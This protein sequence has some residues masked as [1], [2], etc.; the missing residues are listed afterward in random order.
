MPKG[1]PSGFVAFDEQRNEVIITFRGTHTPDDW[2]TNANSELV[3]TGHCEGCR[4][5]AGFFKS[6]KTAKPLVMS[7][8]QDALQQSPDAQ[9][10]IAGHSSGAAIGSFAGLDLPGSIQVYTLFGFQSF[11]PCHRQFADWPFLVGNAVFVRL[12][13]GWEPGTLAS[14]Q[15]IIESGVPIQSQA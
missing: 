14:N 5:H 11:R 6:W 8:V 10:V 3:N 12:P 1:G 15:R 2:F 13:Q 4:G 7:A 9:V